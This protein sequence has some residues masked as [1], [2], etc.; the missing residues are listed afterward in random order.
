MNTIGRK[1]YFNFGN[2]IIAVEIICDSAAEF[3][4]RT[5]LSVDE[6]HSPVCEVIDC[7]GQ[8]TERL[9]GNLMAEPNYT[10]YEKLSDFLQEVKFITN[11]DIV[12]FCKYSKTPKTMF[13]PEDLNL[14]VKDFTSVDCWMS[15][16]KGFINIPDDSISASYNCLHP[17]SIKE[18]N[19]LFVPVYVFNKNKHFFDDVDT[20]CEEKNWIVMFLG[21]DNASYGQRFK[22]ETEAYD[23]V[24]KG[25]ECGFQKLRFYNS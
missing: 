2:K 12:N 15:G 8:K 25:F 22:S 1:T 9:V 24:S 21:T 16:F 18:D 5:G 13:S 3:K 4:Q 14:N 17:I 11:E 7:L 23:F 19:K 20:D 6:K 10:S